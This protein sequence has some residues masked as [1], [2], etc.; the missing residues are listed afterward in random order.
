MYPLNEHI[1][2]HGD[3]SQI[4][5]YKFADMLAKTFCKTCGVSMTN[6][7]L[8]LSEEQLSKLPEIYRLINENHS[9]M[10]PVNVRVLHGVDLKQLVIEHF[11]GAGKIK[12]PAYVNP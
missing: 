5:R 12:Q 4:G 11:D 1:V 3:E 7:H 8:G 9:K 2:L 10:L 6:E